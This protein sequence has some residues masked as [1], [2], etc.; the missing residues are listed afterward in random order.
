MGYMVDTRG[1]KPDLVRCTGDAFERY[2]PRTPEKWKGSKSLDAFAWGG[3]DF[4]WY[5]EI[6]DAKAKEYMKEIDDFWAK[7]AKKG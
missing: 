3:G 7:S 4:V 1:P 5:D 6:S 2:D